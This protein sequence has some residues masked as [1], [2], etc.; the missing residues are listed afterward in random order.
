MF[1]TAFFIFAKNKLISEYLENPVYV[2][3][4][5]YYPAIK[6]SK[7]LIHTTMQRNLKH[8]RISKRHRS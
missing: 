4:M 8:I 5:E 2:H 6:E 7:L 3:T 1:I